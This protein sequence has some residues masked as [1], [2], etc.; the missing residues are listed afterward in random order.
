VI[1]L[2]NFNNAHTAQTTVVIRGPTFHTGPSLFRSR[3]TAPHVFNQ[4]SIFSTAEN[5]AV[6]A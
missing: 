3:L 1:G 4:P 2:D 5:S 6:P